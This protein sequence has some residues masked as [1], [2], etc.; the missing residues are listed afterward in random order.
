LEEKRNP[1]AVII[2][3]SFAGINAALTLKRLEPGFEVIVLDKDDCFTMMPALY[4]TAARGEGNAEI[5]V[6]LASVAK[7]HGFTFFHDEAVFV[8]RKK[9]RVNTRNGEK[10]SFDYLVIAIGARTNYYAVEG[11]EKHALNLKR[12]QDGEKISERLRLGLLRGKPLK[13]VVCGGGMSGIQFTSELADW[14]KGQGG[15]HEIRL[16][17]TAPRLASELPEEFSELARKSLERKSVKVMLNTPVSRVMK[18][19]VETTAGAKHDADLVLWCGGNKPPEALAKTGLPLENGYVATN[20][21][22]QSPAEERIFAAGDCTA[23]KTHDGKP[24][25]Q[26]VWNAV[27]EGRTAAQNISRHFRGRPL[28]PYSASNVP[29]VFTLGRN[30]GVLYYKGIMLTGRLVA[31]LKRFVERTYLNAL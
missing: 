11:V 21:F 29:I 16:F 28:I 4:E 8:D 5:S 23:V 24:A 20:E 26:T 9:R 6:S 27:L 22:L 30:Y 13:I 7:K 18:K 25:Y 10:I 3:A 12:R 31:W 15:G 14:L 19:G 17:H 2:G 1:T